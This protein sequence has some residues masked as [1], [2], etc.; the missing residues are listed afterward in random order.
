MPK[1]GRPKGGANRY[2]SREDKYSV[3]KPIIDGKATYRETLKK[4]KICRSQLR[5]WLKRFY[6]SGIAG[7]E[8]KRKPG[9]PIAALH[10][11]KSLTEVERMRL[12]LMKKDIEI[13]RLK[14]GYT[15]KEVD[16]AHEKLS[17]RNMR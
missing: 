7:L 1:G 3:I 6:E 13:Q 11:S 14:K 12:E 17:K 10:T 5:N 4:T 2:W 16:L 8:N 9:N 15:Q